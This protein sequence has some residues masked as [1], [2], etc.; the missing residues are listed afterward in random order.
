MARVA[1]REG[2]AFEVLVGRHARML[3]RLAYRMLGDT[4]A[5]EDVAQESLLRLWDH[6]AR[7]RGD[8]PGVGP[9]L[10]RVATNLCFDRLR[11]NKFV[12]AED[13][14]DRADQS[15]A[16]DDIMDEE[17]MRMVTI[18]CIGTLSDRQR[19]A[20]I[21]T[22]YEDM[23]NA[24]AASALDMNIKAFESLLL[25]SRLALRKAIETN[26][27]LPDFANRGSA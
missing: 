12:S 15:P 1:A 20:I 18:A 3:H 27:L 13:V 24:E 9:W 16:A 2:T 11:R 5:A 6:A 4:Q 23:T 21:L 26:G 7:W 19:A 14:P 25:R 8:G 10:K 22:Y 17:R